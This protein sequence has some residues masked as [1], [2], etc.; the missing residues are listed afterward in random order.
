MI[1]DD[2]RLVKVDFTHMS[3][4]IRQVTERYEK[5]EGYSSKWTNFVLADI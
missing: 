4:E 5:Y 2:E 3:K 1:Y